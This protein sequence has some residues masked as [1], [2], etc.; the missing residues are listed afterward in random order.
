MDHQVLPGAL[1]YAGVYHE[2]SKDWEGPAG[3]YMNDRRKILSP[4]ESEVFTPIAL[5]AERHF[6]PDVMGIAFEG[7][8]FNPPPQ[9]RQYFL[10]LLYVP[11]GI[12]G[13]PPVGTIWEAPSDGPF[14]VT[15]PTYRWTLPEP[16]YGSPDPAGYLFS[17]TMTPV[18]PEPASFFGLILGA[19][20]SDASRGVPSRVI[21]S[22]G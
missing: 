14:S 15:V 7:D 10:E 1:G 13:A 19:V 18:I 16:N 12:E 20:L 6:E 22:R 8:E 4:L 9:D 2:T 21:S 17:F 3:Y 11:E 5:W